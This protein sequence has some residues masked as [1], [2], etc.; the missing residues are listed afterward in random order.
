M[1]ISEARE[2]APALPETVEQD[3]HGIPSLRVRGKIF[4]TV[5]DRDHLRIM[6][7]EGDILAAVAE[8]PAACEEFWWGARLAC[9]VVDLRSATR[10]VVVELL[11]DAWR[12]K[13][14]R[15]VIRDSTASRTA[16]SHSPVSSSTPTA[17]AWAT[18]PED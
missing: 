17:R 2:L 5:P 8:N 18:P 6:V 3:H 13:A 11:L 9:V 15:R 14:P 16:H 4:A 10:E 1:T 7:S 12:R